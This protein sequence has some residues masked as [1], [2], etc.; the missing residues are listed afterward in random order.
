M[1]LLCEYFCDSSVVRP[2]RLIAPLA[3]RRPI[4]FKVD[5][6]PRFPEAVALLASENELRGH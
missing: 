1:A 5:I 2:S 3:V 6:S 4:P